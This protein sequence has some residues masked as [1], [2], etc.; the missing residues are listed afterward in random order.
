MKHIPLATIVLFCCVSCSGPATDRAAASEEHAID[1]TY[2]RLAE[3]VRQET[4]R[5]W[6]AYK[7]YAWGHDALKP[8]T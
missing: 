3:E 5:S 7:Q 4:L 2:L 1:S 8:L 6:K